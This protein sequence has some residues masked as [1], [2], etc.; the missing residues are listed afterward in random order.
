MNTS[1]PALKKYLALSICGLSFALMSS[2]NVAQASDYNELKAQVEPPTKKLS[3]SKA[4]KELPKIYH[5]IQQEL[6]NERSEERLS[7]IYCGCPISVKLNRNQKSLSYNWSD[8][9]FSDCGYK[10]RKNRNRARRIE[11]EHVMPAWEFGHKLSCWKAG[12]RDNCD[13]DNKFKYREGD[14]H[15]LY[16]SVGEVNGDRANYKFVENLANAKFTYGQCQM[17]IDSKKEMAEPPESS[18]GMIARSYLYMHNAYDI[19]LSKEQLN[20]FIRWDEQ[21]AP[22]KIE[23][24]RNELIKKVQGNVNPFIDAKRC[25]KY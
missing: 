24:R 14:L 23:C 2:T 8:I 15:N 7:T 21:Y 4:K 6:K 25:K 22:S 16:P 10:V 9:K 5:Q 11:I 12:G 18:R 20:Q 19:A 3:F 1:L 13:Q 17:R